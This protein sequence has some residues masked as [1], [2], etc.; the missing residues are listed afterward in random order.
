MTATVPNMILQP[1]FENAIKYGVYE[2]TEP[3][4]IITTCRL[5]N[6]FLEII[7]QNTY[8]P[9][10]L[11]KKGEG[12]GLKNIRDRLEIIYNNP[13]L[14]KIND[15]NNTFTVTILIPQK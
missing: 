15:L 5:V 2:A 14:I 9:D 12:I 7:I 3:V 6:D 4:D 10:V 1:L 11:H 8:D 13:G